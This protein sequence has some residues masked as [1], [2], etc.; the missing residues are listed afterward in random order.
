MNYKNALIIVRG[1]P[2]SGKSTLAR[3]I[4]SELKAKNIDTAH[5]EA[6]SFFINDGKYVF[7]ARKLGR[8]HSNC[9]ENTKNALNA[10]STVIVSNTFTTLKELKPYIALTDNNMVIVVNKSLPL[11]LNFKRT[12]HEVPMEA[13]EKMQNR[14]AKY[15][16]EVF[17]DERVHDIE[18]NL[19]DEFVYGVY[20][21]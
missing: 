6:D 11:D 10:G 15:P 12:I 17:F 1:L 2:G 8:A 19:T 13:L 7:D 9:F 20:H 4:L 14:W 5:Y 16:G 18:G 21:L 3:K